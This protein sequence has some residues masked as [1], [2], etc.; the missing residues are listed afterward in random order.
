MKAIL[1]AA[2][3]GRRLDGDRQKALIEIGGRTLLARHADN[4]FRAQAEVRVVTGFQ[5]E[6]LEPYLQGADVVFNPDFERGSLLSLQHGLEGVDDDVV[7]MDADVLY[8]PSILFEVMALERGLA[9]DTDVTPGD[10]E[11]MVGVRDER[12]VGIRRGLSS[13]GLDLVGEGV[14]FFSLE[15]RMVP[16]LMEAIEE[17]DPDGDYEAALDLFL[18]EFGADYVQVDGRPWIEID[19]PDDVARAA[20]AVLPRL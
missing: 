20:D 14:G 7:I 17:C 11:M 2:G 1:L 8:H 19:F 16:L 15:R 13:E 18:G 12:V 4:L 3:V 6:R 5:A 9:I 10:E